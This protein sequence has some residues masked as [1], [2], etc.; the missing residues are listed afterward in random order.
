MTWRSILADLGLLVILGQ[1]GHAGEPP[2]SG[3]R[4]EAAA[5]VEARVGE[6]LEAASSYLEEDAAKREAAK[7][8]LV[9]IGA[10]AA[11]LLVAR[12]DS[13]NIMEQIA[14]FDV[15]PRI[16]EPAVDVL[17]AAFLGPGSPQIHRGA[18]TLI[19]KIG[20]RRSA[21][22]LTQA[23]TDGDWAIRAAAA[24]GLGRLAADLPEAREH[25]YK[26]LGDEDWGV[27]L[28][29]VWA[30]GDAGLGGEVKALAPLLEDAHF[31][32]RLAAAELLAAQGTSGVAAIARRLEEHNPTR[33]G[34]LSC[35]EAL[36]RTHH[37]GAAVHVEPFLIDADAVVR[38]YA[39]RAYGDTAAQTGVVLCEALLDEE[40]DRNVRL[41]LQ[42]ALTAIKA[43]IGN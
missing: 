24:D 6:L 27:R 25:V 3:N 13:T 21:A 28:R 23:A 19:G 16:G 37:P 41:A 12:L 14:L 11:P 10:P 15:L 1:G 9:E 42:A 17:H 4:D 39:A 31:G 29:A 26:L 35:L 20:S 7:T 34:K 40:M 38:V 43:R 30:I 32:V 8:A 22:I 5:A 18:I 33:V 2:A 36:G